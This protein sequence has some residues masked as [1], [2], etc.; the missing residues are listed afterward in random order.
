[1]PAFPSL[2][3]KTVSTDRWWLTH[4]RS[5]ASRLTRSKKSTD[6]TV[7]DNSSSPF[8]YMK[9]RSGKKYVEV[10]EERLYL[11]EDRSGVNTNRWEME[12]VSRKSATDSNMA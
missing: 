10:D 9:Q 4:F 2:I 5:L 7:S 1:M 3:R 8:D 6:H 11:G 12:T